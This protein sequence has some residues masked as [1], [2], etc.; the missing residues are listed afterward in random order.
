M[1]SRILIFVGILVVVAGMAAYFKVEAN[2][3]NQIQRR[4]V[5]NM[6]LLSSAAV[7]HAMNNELSL[8]TRIEAAVLVQYFPDHSSLKCP[9]GDAEYPPF[10]IKEGPHCPNSE[11]HTKAKRQEPKLQHR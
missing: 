4:C 6:E 11:E 3:A 7:S 8:D 10:V 9:L 2:R 1:R 5:G